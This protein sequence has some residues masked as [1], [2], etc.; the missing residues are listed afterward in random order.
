MEPT[1]L[2]FRRNICPRCRGQLFASICIEF[3]FD[4]EDLVAQEKLESIMEKVDIYCEK[5]CQLEEKL[6]ERLF[7]D[8]CAKL[9]ATLLDFT[10]ASLERA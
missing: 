5:G 8:F 4:E 10:R 3:L 9:R 2:R 6:E 1:I 7:Y